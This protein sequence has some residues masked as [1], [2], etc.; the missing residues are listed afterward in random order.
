MSDTHGAANAPSGERAQAS[1]PGPSLKARALKLLSMREHTRLELE[2]KLRA[3][4]ETPEQL[5][6]AL[7]ALQAKG[8]INEAR[9]V[10]SVLHRR[11][12]R[13]GASRV[14]Q[15]LQAI[16]VADVAIAEAVEHLRSTELAR[17]RE[18]WEKK[19]GA[20]AQDAKERAKQIRFLISRGFGAEVVRRVVAGADDA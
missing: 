13:L 8:F 12:A 10:E 18:V 5:S 20:P 16:G 6:Q 9:V 1:K 14:R 11:A 2:R 19:F 3:H 7:D 4:A 15:E 17:A